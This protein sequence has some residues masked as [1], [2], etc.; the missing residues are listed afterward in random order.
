M[1]D[2]NDAQLTRALSAFAFEG[3]ASDV[4]RTTAGH[5]HHTY[6]VTAE[7]GAQKRRFTLQRINKYV[8]TSPQRVMENISAVT[9]YL[10]AQLAALGDDPSRGTINIV[11]THN[12]KSF[13]LD[14]DG[15][16]W[17]LYSY[18]EN[19]F[20]LQRAQN[21]RE[22]FEAA[23]AFGRFQLMLCDYPAKTLH[24]TIPHFHDP[25]SRM[26]QLKAALAADEY[27]RSTDVAH[28]LSVINAHSALL[29]KGEYFAGG[30]LPLRVTHND[31]KL[32]NVLLDD[33]TG[34]A[35]CVIDL[36]TIMPGLSIYDFGDGVRCG[37]SSAEE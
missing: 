5:I 20:T 10:R 31:T 14:S 8:F 33:K 26:Q 30:A 6:L 1:G 35:V 22:L 36:D 11:K 21:P 15:E 2:P 12:G 13:F 28:W 9:D 24:E 27:S 23:H 25:K 16:Y 37:A 32:N 17:R 18:I 4:V 29:E 7:S 19:T 3:K 34:R